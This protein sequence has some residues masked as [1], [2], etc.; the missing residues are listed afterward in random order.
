[1]HIN[2]YINSGSLLNLNFMIKESINIIIQKTI[3]KIRVGKL[4]VFPIKLISIHPQHP[5]NIQPIR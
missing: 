3:S 4:K 5:P 2:K 1:M